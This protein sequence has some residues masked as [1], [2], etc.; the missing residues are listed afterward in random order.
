VELEPLGQVRRLVAIDDAGRQVVL[1]LA[2]AR[3]PFL[4]IV[5]PEVPVLPGDQDQRLGVGH[6]ADRDAR[7]GEGVV[8]AV[9]ELEMARIRLRRAGLNESLVQEVLEAAEGGET[10]DR[11][12]ARCGP[13]IQQRADREGEGLDLLRGH[14]LGGAPSEQVD[15]LVGREVGIAEREQGEREALLVGLGPGL[16]GAHVAPDR[17]L[18]GSPPSHRRVERLDELPDR[19]SFACCAEYLLDRPGEREAIFALGDVEDRVGAPVGR[20]GEHPPP[21]LVAHATR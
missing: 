11:E 16:E 19:R 1:R 4:A 10:H 18:R 20:P 12:A 7:A 3:P 13:E 21:A 2:L 15:A 5:E 6:V 17:D 8:H 9:R 14:P